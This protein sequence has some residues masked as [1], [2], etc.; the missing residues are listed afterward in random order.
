M[1]LL[2]LLLWEGGKTLPIDLTS[3]FFKDVKKTAK[4][5]D[6]FCNKYS[7]IMFQGRYRIEHISV[8]IYSP[9]FLFIT[10]CLDMKRTKTLLKLFCTVTYNF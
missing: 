8:Q 2:G 9:L 3:F 6:L 10:K 4:L 5:G 7:R 1:L